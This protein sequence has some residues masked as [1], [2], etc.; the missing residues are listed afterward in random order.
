MTEPDLTTK[1]GR[2]AW[3]HDLRMV[4][5]RPRRVG[6]VLLAV[7]M[8]LGAMPFGGMHSL[9]GWSPRFL[10]LCAVALA[11]PFLIAATLLRRRYKR[12][13]MN[14]GGVDRA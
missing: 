13:I 14:A 3:K 8:M 6:L 11:V 7:A 12:Q 1:Q 2:K 5:V 10:A 9:W 4:A